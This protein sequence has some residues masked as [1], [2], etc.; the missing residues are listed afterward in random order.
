[1]EKIVVKGSM[2]SFYDMSL[3]KETINSFY[4]PDIRV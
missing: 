1:M 3:M 4:V 2:F